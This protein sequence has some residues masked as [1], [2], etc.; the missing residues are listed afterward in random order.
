MSMS[1]PESAAAVFRFS[2]PFYDMPR[3]IAWLQ[4]TQWSWR[5]LDGE[6]CDDIAVDVPT[7]GMPALWGDM[8][9]MQRYRA[10]GSQT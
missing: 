4:S 6:R 10:R 1:D 8:V 5:P 9:G 7:A 2:E 3:V